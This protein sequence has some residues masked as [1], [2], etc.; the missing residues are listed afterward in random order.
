M[1]ADL[2]FGMVLATAATSRSGVLLVNPGQEITPGL[3]TRLEN[4]AA[5]EDGVAE[6]LMVLDRVDVT[7]SAED[8]PA[9]TG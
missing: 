4:F 5:L 2:Q 7:P 9:A 8:A 6:P 1:L 3:L